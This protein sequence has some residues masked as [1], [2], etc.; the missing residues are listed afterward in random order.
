MQPEAH[1]REQET[2]EICP[3]CG[4]RMHSTEDVC[5]LCGFDA[6]EVIPVAADDARTASSPVSAPVRDEGNT[7][8]GVFCNQ[9]GWRNPLGARFCSRC[10]TALQDLAAEAIAAAP[11]PL[12]EPVLSP[13]AA[14]EPPAAPK[15][16]ADFRPYSSFWR[17]MQ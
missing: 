15:R 10:G 16:A 6:R 14:S 2:N 8:A 11:V 7:E 12:S 9:C 3:E 13:A 17:F 5:S 4:A 1:V